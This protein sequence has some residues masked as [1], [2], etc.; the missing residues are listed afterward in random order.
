M[1]HDDICS[2]GCSNSTT[3]EGL[4]SH[5][6]RDHLKGVIGGSGALIAGLGG[7]GL[8][9][10]NEGE[11]ED[12]SY[13]EVTATRG[14]NIAP[15]SDGEHVVMDL[16]G[17]LFRFPI[18]GG[19]AERLTDVEL[20]PARPHYSPNGDRITFQGYAG[21]EF[22]IWTIAPDG[23]DVRQ[24]TDTRWDDREPRWSPDGSRIA[25]SSDRGE[26]YDIWTYDCGTGEVQQWT[27]DERE[28][29]EPTW[30][31]N[32]DEIAY[33][34]DN[35]IEAINEEGE[36]RTL[37]EAED[38]ESFDS[39][40]W[41]PDGE[42]AYI[43]R[44]DPEDRAQIIELVV[45]GEVVSE[46]E[47]V[48][49]FTPDWLSENEIVYGGDGDV[50]LYNRGDD[51]NSKIPF[52]ADFIVPDV[53]FGK[54]TYVHELD[55]GEE[56]PVKGILTPRLHPDGDRIAF[57]ALND[58][59]VVENGEEPEQITDDQWYQSDP[60]WSP[61]G[62]YL[63]YSS[64]KPGTQELYVYDTETGDHRRV[65]NIDDAVVSTAWAPDGST[66]AYQNQWRETYTLEVEISEDEID[67]G[68][69][70]QWTDDLFLPGR[71]TFSGDSNTLALGALYEYSNRFREGTSRILTIDLE[72]G[73][74]EWYYPGEDF[75]SLATR[76]HDG[77][78]WSPDGNYMAFVVES[79]LRVMPVDD[80]GEPTGPAEQITNEATDAPTWSGDSEW[81]L[82]LN[83]G[84]LKKVRRDGSE[85]EEIS[86]DLTYEID[87]PSGSQT[88]FVG[89]LW[90]GTGSE[91][92]E[93]V[94]IEIENNRI[95]D[96]ITDT[97]PPDGEYVDCSDLTVYP[98]M[99]DVHCH[100]S[101]SDR[102]FGTRQGAINLAYGVTTTASCG[103]KVYN[104]IEER[105]AHRAHKRPGP[106][107]F[108][109]GEPID[110]SRIAYGFI[111][112][113]TTSVDDILEYE[114][115]RILE[116]DYDFVKTYVRLSAEA[117]SEVVDFAHNEVGVLTGSH[118]LAPGAFV[119]QAGTTH[120]SA[121]QRLGYAR[122]ESETNQTYQD[123]HNIYGDGQ[124]DIQTTLAQGDFYLEDDVQ[125]A[126]VDLFPEWENGEGLYEY[127]HFTTTRQDLL[128]E[129]EGQTEFPED[130]DCETGLCRNVQ[131]FKDIY[132]AGGNVMTGTDQPLEHV[133]IGQ[134]VELRV[135]TEYAFEEHE[136][137]QAATRDP[138]EAYG[139]GD[140]LGTIEPGKLADMVFV[141]GNPLEDITD[142]NNIEQVMKNGR[143]YSLADLLE[144][145]PE[146]SAESDY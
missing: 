41:G 137:L 105:E 98:G 9:S 103:D 32:G 90:D 111:G 129:A 58:L 94:C 22:N 116:M 49:H 69:P 79:T 50:L 143:L 7:S 112:R 87:C 6:R 19:E 123:I 51:E 104:A 13:E 54:K 108:A 62:R 45:D 142:A 83:N 134:Q 39:P 65:T 125:D 102:F 77:P 17:F 133:G 100:T 75:D 127:P 145:T 85:T 141:D 40:S 2:G 101:Y 28:N 12:I 53:D 114:L 132:D 23:S 43:Q 106:R 48:F 15:T 35:A 110:G 82:Y 138:A 18:E 31:P 139:V 25:F 76:G 44:T 10:A 117:M 70:E 78:V 88:I 61:D 38:N 59:W 66:I 122:T 52:E 113:V 136:A 95:V 27:D 8:T 80:D 34:T 130:P 120:L 20:E 86:C 63:A 73:D 47:D 21:G 124:R 16:H 81:L 118:Y 109:S 107:S 5:T 37:V 60:V 67:T 97:E 144:M 93:D 131:T 71:P 64:D 89:K 119:C 3:G 33:V 36:T 42:L 29:F 84:R 91:V 24:L 92:D 74:E 72:T 146:G 26:Y 128:N 126:R 46:T 99:W 140:H 135:L 68:E 30:S 14:T 55:G 1:T 57:V 4:L 115:D 11:L 56:Q 96:V 121:T